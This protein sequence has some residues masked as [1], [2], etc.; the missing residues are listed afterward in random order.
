MEKIK[1]EGFWAG[2]SHSM[3]SVGKAPFPD[4][5][6]IKASSYSEAEKI[7]RNYIKDKKTP[8][9]CW[10]LEKKVSFDLDGHVYCKISEIR[11]YRYIEKTREL[12][13]SKSKRKVIDMSKFINSF[14][15]YVKQYGKYIRTK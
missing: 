15:P 3:Y 1:V 12:R 7:L 6:N 9:S 14:K 11:A 13:E 10:V 4:S 2:A 8:F 5:L